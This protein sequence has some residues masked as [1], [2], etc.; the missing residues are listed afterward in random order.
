MS[1][2]SFNEL[3]ISI[4]GLSM[5]LNDEHRVP[6]AEA[7]ATEDL[8]LVNV[9][10]VN[11]IPLT[12]DQYQNDLA[13]QR[14]ALT[15]W[16]AWEAAKYE[17]YVAGKVKQNLLPSDKSF[18][19]QIKRMTYRMKVIDV[20]RSSASATWI[21]KGNLNITSFSE[22]AQEAEFLSTVNN[23]LKTR[24]L[25]TGNLPKEFCA[26]L[27]AI[28][29]TIALNDTKTAQPFLVTHV[30]HQFDD[31]QRKLVPVIKVNWFKVTKE[32]IPR[33]SPANVLVHYEF[34]DCTL[35]FDLNMWEKIKTEIPGDDLE[36]GNGILKERTLNLTVC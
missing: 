25:Q 13:A 14:K 32:S 21:A 3:D 12:E 30:I 35:E 2:E 7:Q 27:N 15:T 9:L 34:S 4:S 22:K 28:S 18:E 17:T 31:R 29:V 19:A 1:T 8:E 6:L 11:Y 10:N 33:S 20:L 24:Y 5:P 36:R 26:I 23:H 16:Q